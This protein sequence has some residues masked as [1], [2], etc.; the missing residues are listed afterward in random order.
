MPRPTSRRS[1]LRR[2]AVERLEGRE[3]LTVYPN[4]GAYPI[5]MNPNPPSGT[6]AFYQTQASG[7]NADGSTVANPVV[8]AG[9]QTLDD[10]TY[11]LKALQT[12]ST[13]TFG[14]NPYTVYSAV[15]DPMTIAS[16]YN[17]TA[18]YYDNGELAGGQID[19]AS[20]APTSLNGGN[21]TALSS[22]PATSPYTN[23]YVYVTQ[24]ASGAGIFI[25]NLPGTGKNDGLTANV[26][27]TND[28]YIGQPG[29]SPNGPSYH[30]EPYGF[31]LDPRVVNEP[32]FF[33]NL[34]PDGSASTGQTF[35][36]ANV[37]NQPAT[38]PEPPFNTWLHLVQ[39]QDHQGVNWRTD[40]ATAVNNL[41]G[42]N[43]WPFPYASWTYNNNPSAP[44]GGIYFPYQPQPGFQ[45]NTLRYYTPSGSWD[46][47]ENTSGLFVRQ[48]GS[49]ELPA[50]PA[51]G[52]PIPLVTQ[53]WDSSQRF[54]ILNLTSRLVPSTVDEYPGNEVYFAGN[55]YLPGQAGVWT[56]FKNY[57]V[58]DSNGLSYR[59][60]DTWLGL[61]GDSADAVQRWDYAVVN[62]ANT[63]PGGQANKPFI[64]DASN[65]NGQITAQFQDSNSMMVAELPSSVSAK[66]YDATYYVDTGSGYV[67]VATLGQTWQPWSLS[68]TGQW[69]NTPW[70]TGYG[71]VVPSLTVYQNQLPSDVT[72]AITTSIGTWNSGGRTI[73]WNTVRNW[74]A[75]DANAVG[76]APE[77]F[78]VNATTTNTNYKF[79]VVLTDASGTTLTGPAGRAPTAVLD[80]SAVGFRSAAV[81]QIHSA[82]NALP[83]G[84]QAAG[85]LHDLAVTA[86][87]YRRNID[88]L[89]SLIRHRPRD[90]PDFR[91]DLTTS[92]RVRIATQAMTADIRRT[93]EFLLRR[94]LPIVRTRF[95]LHQ[96]EARI[97]RY[98][99]RVAR[100][101]GF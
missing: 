57:T 6:G 54:S 31:A 76:Q 49:I 86:L 75:G 12:G 62:G 16:A 73:A 11:Q 33:Y 3:L 55:A 44:A 19:F 59:R 25:P 52:Q 9:T 93:S 35:L 60:P 68:G 88:T 18:R 79:L 72:V 100:L 71:S 97:N 80:Y 48:D 69:Q 34:T 77:F 27:W 50:D 90:V 81:D 39:G 2:V 8:A 58:F 64:M 96:L 40:F 22:S 101:T 20:T 85:D 21:P 45:S 47:L 24:P 95:V 63:E 10:V 32:I 26:Y 67:K 13:I 17:H 53:T 14:G 43:N 89:T 99:N 56:S 74:Q 83:P 92:A 37:P 46:E 15:P 42:Q 28:P 91:R 87:A 98:T 38:N 5:P 36:P 29:Y 30:L 7:L 51:T 78:T 1:P 23:D 41:I 94:D 82:L 84:R 61:Q 4:V 66:L 70:Q 65:Q